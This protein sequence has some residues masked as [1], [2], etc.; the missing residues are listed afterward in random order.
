MAVKSKPSSDSHSLLVP[1]N[2]VLVRTVTA[3]FTGVCLGKDEHEVWFGDASWIADT[4]R[5]H[6][7][8]KDGTVNEVE[9]IPDGKLTIGR[10]AIVDVENFA[11]DLPRQQK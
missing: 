5:F 10:G 3:Y 2:K 6:Q 9:P 4:G 1:G 11:H 8:L 7:F